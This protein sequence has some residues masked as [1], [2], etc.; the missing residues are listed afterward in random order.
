[1]K[2]L[3]GLFLCV[4][5]TLVA[6]CQDA[7]RP[8][9]EGPPLLSQGQVVPDR[10]IV[11]FNDGV[12]NPRAAAQAIA[13][14]QGLALRHVYGTA[15]KGF[16]GTIPAARLDAVRSDPRVV[17]VEG[18]RAYEL[19]FQQVLPTGIDRIETDKN[20]N[21][22]GVTVEQDVGLLDSG[23]D[24]DHP[25]LNVAGG[26]NFSSGN[27][28]K[29]DDRNGHGTH[30]AGTVG[31]IDNGS[32]VVGVA[33]G[34]RLW[35]VKV[36]KNRG[37]CMTG[38]M[39][40]G[41]DWMAA[42]K[43]DGIINFA[44]ANMSISTSDD[45]DPCTGSSGAVHKA[46]CGLVDEGVVFALS[47]GNNGREKDAFPEVLAVSALADFD[48]KGGG[49][50]SPTCRSDEDD[51]L[52]NFSNFGPEVDIAAP[53]VCILSTW[54]DGGTN[55]ISGTSMASPH[56][57]GAVALYLHANKLAPATDAAG[58]DVIEAAIISAA[59]PEGITET[60]PC[61]Y[62]N[63][64]GSSEPLL[65]VNGAAFG[66]D[67]SCD[68][69]TPPA[70]VTDIAITAVSAPNSVTQGDV[71]DVS[72]TVDNVGNQDVGADITVTLT[73]TPPTGGTV[74]TVSAA[75]TI[76]GG[77][78][79]GTSTTLT[80]TWNTDV[81]SLGDHT[82]TASHDLAD[83][84]ETNDSKSTTVTVN[85]PTVGTAP[86]VDACTP[87]NGN[88]GD[89][90]TV[91]VTGSNFQDGATADFGERVTVQ[92]V[93]F[94]DS[95]QLDVRIKVHPRATSGSRDVTVTNP[96]GKSGTGAGCFTVN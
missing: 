79:A 54:N 12:A 64:K 32:G 69:A 34:V 84:D 95:D 77:L 67:G 26:R 6:G 5:I 23:I 83:D 25:D 7:T 37:I 93:T 17:L 21:A 36:C 68:L 76:V 59:L 35:A 41:I 92:N 8:E 78:T 63:E 22:E 62:N 51:T 57:A 73:D 11:L 20:L 42:Q 81:A 13:R 47:A 90:L 60:N 89:R 40:A 38:D 94:V 53:G 91:A 52:A 86:V 39:V 2:K 31:A 18:E 88:P 44:A 50:G 87:N 9:V 80:F 71:V 82:L 45:K 46:I 28:N 30:T 55:T 65:F 19:D 49:L 1:M 85:E 24:Q 66:G 96:D 33:P 4:L 74:G 43:A 70:P 75:Q 3:T 27:P 16:A 29:W 56:V 14:A 48:G 72:V 61:S 58:V 10:Y 15:V